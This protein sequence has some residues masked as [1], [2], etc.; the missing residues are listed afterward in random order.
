MCKCVHVGCTLAGES[1]GL[2]IPN[3][4]TVGRTP[5]KVHSS[6]PVTNNSIDVPVDDVYKRSLLP[7]TIHDGLD[8]THAVGDE[9]NVAAVDICCVEGFCCSKKLDKADQANSAPCDLHLFITQ[10]PFDLHLFY[11]P[12]ENQACLSLLDTWLGSCSHEAISVVRLEKRH[13]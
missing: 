6:L 8:G 11:E 12:S 5:H 13:Y 9:D 4:A 10:P 1:V 7:S 2:F 3:D